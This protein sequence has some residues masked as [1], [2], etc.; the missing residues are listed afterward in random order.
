MPTVFWLDSMAYTATAV[1]AIALFFIVLGTSPQRSENRLFAATV[2]VVALW[3]SA[4]TMVRVLLAADAP[5]AIRWLEFGAFCFGLLGPL[6]LAFTARYTRQTSSWLNMASGL[7]FIFCLVWAIPLAQHRLILNPH[8]SPRGIV[9]Y[10]ITPVGYIAASVPFLYFAWT[11]LIFR[12]QHVHRDQPY[13][14]LG[15]SI[16]IFGFLVGGLLVPGLPILPIT[17][18][19]AMLLL[20]YGIVKEQV[21]NPLR[22]MNLQLERRVAERTHELEQ[23]RAL[24]QTLLD[25]LPDLV[26]VKDA[27]GRILNANRAYLEATGASSLDEIL[28]KT[29]FE[30]FPP[31]LAAQYYADDQITLRSETPLINQEEPIINPQGERRWMLTSR[32]PLRDGQG[33]VTGLVGIAR[34]ITARKAAETA[35]QA[36]HIQTEQILAAIPAVL[37][38]VT[39]D[40]IVAQ[41]N[42]TAEKAFKIGVMEAIGVPLQQLPIRWD[43]DRLHEAMRRCLAAEAQVQLLELRYSLQGQRERFLDVIMSPFVLEGQQKP[44]VLISAQDVT[45]RVALEAQLRQAQ[46]LESIG[47]LA[48]GIA[49]EI[50]T[51]A[52]YVGDNLRFLQESFTHL[53]RAIEQYRA[54]LN[55]GVPED[56]PGKPAPIEQD[57]DLAFILEEIPQA[58]A[59]SLEGIQHISRIVGAMKEFSHP[60]VQTATAIDINKAIESTLIISRNEWKYVADVQLDLADDLPPVTCQ[61]GE[62]NQ[63][64]LNII[65]NAAHA[66]AEARQRNGSSHKGTISVSTRRVDDRVEIRIRDTG[67]GIPEAIRD[68]IFEPFFTPKDV[69]K[70]TGQGLA[71]AYH[72]I[73]EKHGGSIDFESEEGVGTTF[74]IQLPIRPAFS[75]ERAE[76]ESANGKTASPVR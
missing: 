41:W 51:P 22:E 30:L 57:D 58:L 24:F 60:G 48:A 47:R 72:F 19:A 28:G 44:G 27:Q 1:V 18:I 67:T 63:A 62:I 4:S 68:R 45:E 42:A 73:V 37:I 2:L 17:A 40:G 15:L 29:D 20:A 49:H 46:K 55:D 23:Q 56:A 70:G 53:A 54:R 66:I 39:A 35:L 7:G 64:I 50:N 9:I 74:I 16:T 3:A 12:R 34:D 43:T 26:Y 71:I 59:Q 8:V 61:P 32:I 38:G 14:P 11:A 52:Q 13:L 75:M 5:G 65:V 6:T 76:R 69:G 33:R 10:E 31:R 21:L 36:A 25:H